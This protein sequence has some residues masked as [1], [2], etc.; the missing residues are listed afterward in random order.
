MLT[1]SLQEY[2]ISTIEYS[3]IKPLTMFLTKNLYKIKLAEKKQDRKKTA[4]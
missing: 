4:L 1:G 3:K 2:G